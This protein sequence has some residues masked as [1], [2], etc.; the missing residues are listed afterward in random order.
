MSVEQNNKEYV[1][2][3]SRQVD[4]G[5]SRL[6]LY[7]SRTETKEEADNQVRVLTKKY[8]DKGHTYECYEVRA[9]ADNVFSGIFDEVMKQLR[10]SD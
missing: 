2:I 7:Y 5:E 4:D 8:R 10:G 3:G 1:V 9:D 6:I